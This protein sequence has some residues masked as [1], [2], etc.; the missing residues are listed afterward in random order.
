MSLFSRFRKN[1]RES[2]KIKRIRQWLRRFQRKSKLKRSEATLR[3]F[4]YLDEVSVNSLIAS[5]LGPI[6][7][8]ITESEHGSIKVELPKAFSSGVDA[9]SQVL[10]KSIVQATFKELY[11]LE[12]GSFPM[13]PIKDRAELVE[14]NSFQ[15]FQ[16]KRELLIAGGW[17]VDPGKLVR[18]QLFEAEVELEAE[19]IFRIRAALSAFQEMI[20]ESPSMF[21]A[22][23]Y[24]K[25][26]R[27]K[28]INLMLEN[29]LVGL[30]PVRGTIVDYRVT[31]FG[32]EEL[33][34][35]KKL[36]Q[37]LSIH[38]ELSDP[39]QLSIVGLAEQ[40]LFWKDFRRVLFAGARFHVLG[41]VAQDGLQ[42]T[43]TPM[44]LGDVLD[45]VIPGFSEIMESMGSNILSSVASLDIRDSGRKI[46]QQRTHMR[47]ALVNYVTLLAEYYEREITMQ[48]LSEIEP[49]VDIHSDSFG[50][51]KERR[52][53]F[54]AVA[55][56]LLQRFGVER[57][58][59]IL[60]TYREVA[61]RDAGFDISGDL[62]HL[63]NSREAS[64]RLLSNEHF[65]VTEFVAI[66]W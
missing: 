35:H 30:I 44:K 59:Y 14:I 34:V 55:E 3:E 46:E 8:E 47:Q 49:L 51:L 45:S 33:V 25:L 31:N 63:S 6:A 4:V 1:L 22:E 18:G 37:R 15:D 53:T 48:D 12:V 52:E 39:I 54:N 10:R 13:R 17:L 9:G 40:S 19:G 5:R 28:Q 41:R 65:L 26:A 16:A 43:W 7:A 66:Y 62:V 60:A 24:E 38:H 2:S 57:D 42:H 27:A 32:D 58:P 20:E 36:L 11:E 29:L 64:S 50:N 21:G 61:L 23:T 56:V